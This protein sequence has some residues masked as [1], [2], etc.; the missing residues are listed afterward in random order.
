MQ[1]LADGPHES[2][3]AGSSPAPGTI[4]LCVE[5]RTTMVLVT[6]FEILNKCGLQRS[7]L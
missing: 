6:C 3:V 2:V 5:V 7:E 1:R 4:W